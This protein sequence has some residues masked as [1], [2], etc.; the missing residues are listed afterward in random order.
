MLM[1]SFPYESGLSDSSG[2]ACSKKCTDERG[3]RATDIHYVGGYFGN[4]S[5]VEMMKELA[6]SGPIAV[7][8]E[9]GASFEEY[10]SG[11]FEESATERA[12]RTTGNAQYAGSAGAFEPT[13]HAVLIVGYG[14][15]NGTKYWRVKNS[16]CRAVACTHARCII[17]IVNR[18]LAV[19]SI[20][21]CLSVCLTA[22]LMSSL[23]CLLLPCVASHVHAVGT[24]FW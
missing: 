21:C 9:P 15:E 18:A 8:I 19:L 13:G 20:L 16:V 10:R 14:V 12:A 22:C 5:E 1:R 7:G 6:A 4:C 3:Y 23:G 2:P 11:I 24:S 17:M